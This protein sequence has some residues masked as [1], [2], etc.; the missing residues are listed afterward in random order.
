MGA[1]C[2]YT[3][4]C[5]R[6]KACWIDFNHSDNEGYEEDDYDIMRM[7]EEDIIDNIECLLAKIGYRNMQNGLCKVELVPTYYGDGLIIDISPAMEEWEPSYNLFL[8]NFDRMEENILRCLHKAGFEL[9]IATSGY[10]SGQYIP[11]GCVKK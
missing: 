5:N 3:H 10:T 1:G 11:K 6:Q 2:Y 7:W 8:A 4:K 9:R